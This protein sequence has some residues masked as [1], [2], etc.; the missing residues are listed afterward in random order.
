MSVYPIA[1][2]S[3]QKMMGY[4]PFYYESSRVMMAIIQGQ[5]TELDK[6]RQAVDETLNQFFVDTATWSLGDWEAELGLPIALTQPDTERRS[7]IKSRI[8]GTGTC[9]IKLVIK[10]AESYDGGTVDV[11]EDFPGH[12][13][14]VIFVDTRGV[15]PNI[16]DLMEALRAIVPAHLDIEYEYAYFLWDELDE[17]QWTWDQLEAL[18][19]TWAQLEV[20]S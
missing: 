7:R 16:N 8:R 14:I 12:L 10:V 2:A 4:L 11:L 19:L 1:S 20:Y 13:V 17:K 9:T 3:G 5:G 15:P 18:V 6:L